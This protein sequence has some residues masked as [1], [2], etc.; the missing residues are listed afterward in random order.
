MFCGIIPLGNIY[1]VAELCRSS[2]K[3][4]IHSHMYHNSIACL[5]PT[6]F[7]FSLYFLSRLSFGSVLPRQSV[8]GEELV[9]RACSLNNM[10]NQCGVFRFEKDTLQVR[11]EQMYSAKK[12]WKKNCFLSLRRKGKT[13]PQTTEQPCINSLIFNQSQAAKKLQCFQ[14]KKDKNRFLAFCL[15]L[16]FFLYHPNKH[17][18]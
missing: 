1:F 17:L 16:P 8:T 13:Q 5:M 15:F 9:I 4:I 14:Q 6:F 18:R 12:N 10:D 2:K 11:A 7:S 3:S